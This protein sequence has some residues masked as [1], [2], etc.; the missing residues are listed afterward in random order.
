MLTFFKT[1]GFWN[2]VLHASWWN[3]KF[4]NNSHVCNSDCKLSE[5]STVAG[6]S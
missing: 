2:K 4:L 1:F 5:E 6:S 3:G